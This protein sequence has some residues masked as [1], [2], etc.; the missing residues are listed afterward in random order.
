MITIGNPEKYIAG[1]YPRLSNERIETKNGAVAQVSEDERESV[2][3]NNSCFK[4]W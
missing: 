2:C 3:G 1:I 4:N